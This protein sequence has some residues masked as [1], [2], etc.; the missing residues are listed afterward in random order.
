ML[1]GNQLYLD[2]KYYVKC[3]SHPSVS[4]YAAFYLDDTPAT[5]MWPPL[6]FSLASAIALTSVCSGM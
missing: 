1:K 3:G 4:H 5:P 2:A 6:T